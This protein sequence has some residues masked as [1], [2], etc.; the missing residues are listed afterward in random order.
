MDNM[1]TFERE[2]SR[3][4]TRA[5]AV[6]VDR[7]ERRVLVS[8]AAIDDFWA[9]PGGRIEI[10]ETS[11]EA[12]MREMREELGVEV[13]VGRLLWVTEEFFEFAGLSWHGIAFYYLVCLP[14]DSPMYDREESSGIEEF[15]EDIFVPEHLR[16]EVN[17]L[18]MIFRWHDRERLHELA[19]YPR[20]LQDRLRVL[21]DTT[22]H[23]IRRE[24]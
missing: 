22:E 9:L 19:L 1:I 17:R 10:G 21:P 7:D 3:F 18:E 12:V 24:D 20:F 23:I 4:S 6:I 14:S 16:A 2:R 5:V 11:S 8:R 15:V 13:E